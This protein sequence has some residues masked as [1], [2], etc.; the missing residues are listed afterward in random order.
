MSTPSQIVSFP[1][2]LVGAYDSCV[3]KGDP[4][5]QDGSRASG[6]WL[7][8]TA[9]SLLPWSMAVNLWFAEQGLYRP[10]LHASGGWL[11][12]ALQVCFPSFLLYLVFFRLGGLR[13]RDLGLERARLLPG[14]LATLVLWFLSNAV[15]Y[16]ALGES[17]APAASMTR[18]PAATYGPLL[19][20]L[21][22]NALW[23]ETVYRGFFLTQLYRW[24]C[25]QG[26]SRRQSLFFAV[27][28]SALAF[29][30]PH[31]PNRLYRHQYE[32]LSSAL[33]DQGRLL[34]TGCFLA[35]VYL[36]TKNLWWL[37]GMHSLANAP[38]LLVGWQGPVSLKFLISLL[39][40]ILTVLWPWLFQRRAAAAP[41]R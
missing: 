29:A 27:L 5:A 6:T 22:G 41:I 39:A 15:A 1:G 26:S 40:T 36:R 13:S 34:I 8:I 23:E 2:E 4:L 9:L 19:A 33:L 21:C 35:W 32:T 25:E 16:A 38:T 17:S 12:P 31:I 20:Q 3:S 37:I 18:A 30:L 11:Q 28:L 14:V 7:V 24:S 10:L